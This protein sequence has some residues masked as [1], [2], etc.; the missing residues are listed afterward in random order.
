[1]RESVQIFGIFLVY[2]LHIFCWVHIKSNLASP[3]IF[4]DS[5]GST[6]YALAAAVWVPGTCRN[7]A[8]S[9]PRIGRL[10]ASRDSWQDAKTAHRL[11]LAAVART[12]KAVQTE[13]IFVATQTLWGR[14]WVNALRDAG[15]EDQ[16]PLPAHHHHPHHPQHHL[17]M[18]MSDLH[19]EFKKPVP[20]HSPIRPQDF[21]LYAG[22]HPYQL[23]A[24]GGSAFHRPLDP[25][26]KP[27]PVSIT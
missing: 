26:G 3:F 14:Q 11:H 9:P 4:A 24:Q 25:S 1:M 21:P 13:Q 10:S 22:G 23:L 7:V 19:D 15:C 8:S 18:R 16:Q 20:P 2:I 12:G 5:N 17:G 6:F 27:I